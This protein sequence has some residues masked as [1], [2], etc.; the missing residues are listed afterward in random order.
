MSNLEELLIF[1]LNLCQY[2]KNISRHI[3][4]YLKTIPQ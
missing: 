4:V 1:Y 3:R 2:E